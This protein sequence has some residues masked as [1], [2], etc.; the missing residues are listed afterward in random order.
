MIRI[1][2]AAPGLDQRNLLGE[3]LGEGFQIAEYDPA[4]PLAEQSRD[5][6]A[7]LLRD[8]PITAEVMDAAPKLKLLQR[9]GQHVVGV[10][11]AH[12]RRRGIFVARVPTA[13]TGA[14]RVVAEHALFLMMAVAKRI[15][16]AQRNVAARIL[17][18]P[19]TI[20]LSGMTLAL[21]GVGKTGAELAK[22][23]RGFDMRVVAVKRTKVPELA[24]TLGLAFLGDMSDLD[25]VLADADVVSLHL[26]LDSATRG[27][28]GR[29]AFARM[30]PGSIF[31]NIARG[32]IVDQAALLAA[33]TSGRLAGAG[34]DVVE[35]EPIDP[36]DPLLAME[37]VVVTPHIAG[38]SDEVHRRLAAAVAENI[39]R[40]VAGQAPLHP[41]SPDE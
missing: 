27:S 15:R 32:P 16:T 21:V 35:E 12:A 18:K 30:K 22:L 28:F 2:K 41:A 34:L 33:L 39:R 19:R 4:R 23:V 24:R 13:V 17:G 5:A 26:P 3:M 10:D 31:V 9:Y 1:V 6:T 37:N 38:D 40:V 14:D 8:V 7:L 29:D 36:A 20:T 25:V 11:F